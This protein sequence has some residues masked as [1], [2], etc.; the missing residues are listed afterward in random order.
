MNSWIELINEP[1]KSEILQL[2]LLS[3]EVIESLPFV[4]VYAIPILFGV[5]MLL[6][7]LDCMFL[8]D[9]DNTQSCIASKTGKED[10]AASKDNFS[11]A[12]TRFLQNDT[13]AAA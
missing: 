10:P 12:A 13:N 8:E 9:R 6:A 2:E 5:I 7:A 3:Q 1:I 11:Q 4:I